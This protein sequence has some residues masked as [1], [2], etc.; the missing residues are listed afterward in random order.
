[1]NEIKILIRPLYKRYGSDLARNDFREQ[2]NQFL[3]F[4][5]VPE[6]GNNV[7][8]ASF[9]SQS[10]IKLQIKIAR[11]VIIKSCKH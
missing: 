2:T 6:R 9:K 8:K 1:M 7:K 3:D 5:D 11:N 4:N 10:L